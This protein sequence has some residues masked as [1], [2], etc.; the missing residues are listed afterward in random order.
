MELAVEHD[1]GLGFILVVMREIHVPLG[2]VEAENHQAKSANDGLRERYHRELGLLEHTYG[3][4]RVKSGSIEKGTVW[5][6]DAIDTFSCQNIVFVV[7]ELLF[8]FTLEH[9][10]I[11]IIYYYCALPIYL[12]IHA[13]K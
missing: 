4:T 2:E 11:F 12:S 5:K 8:D 13:I 6:S 3:E 9:L 1:H 7:V 10:F